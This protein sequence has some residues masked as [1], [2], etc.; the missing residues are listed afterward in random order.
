MV[1]NSE[2]NCN[3]V[4]AGSSAGCIAVVGS[5][6]TAVAAVAAV[7]NAVVV[8]V[9]AGVGNVVEYFEY[10][11]VVAVVAAEHFVAVVLDPT[12]RYSSTQGDYRHHSRTIC[13]HP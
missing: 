1:N 4:G 2:R 8:A 12:P 3:F 5:Y 6:Y 9:A 13:P 10:S 7:D 11:A